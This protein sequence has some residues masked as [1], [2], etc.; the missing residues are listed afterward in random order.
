MYVQ[1]YPIHSAI[2]DIKHMYK[3]VCVFIFESGYD[4]L[5]GYCFD[6]LCK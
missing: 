1:K 4:Y 2:H 6:Q 3:Y 5:K